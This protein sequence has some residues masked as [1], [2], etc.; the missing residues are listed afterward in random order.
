M[1]SRREVLAT[2]A[3]AVGATALPLSAGAP[4]ARAAVADPDP[5]R[6]PGRGPNV[7]LIVLDD[8][9]Y[10]DLGCYGSELI[11]TPHLDRLARQGTRFTQGY[12][13]A[14]V[15][16]PSRAALLTGRVPPR[17]GVR[18][19]LSRD[20]SQGLRAAEKTLPGYLRD[21][22][23]HTA[24]IG[25]WHLGRLDENHPSRHGFDSYFGVDAMFSED[26]YPTEIWR[27][28]A[29]VGT[30]RDDADLATLTRRFT[31]EAIDVIDRAGKRPFFIYL[32]E[33]MPHLPLA[34][35]P[36]F[37][38]IS[39]GGLYGDAVESVDHHLGR[40]FRAL[41]DRGLERDTLVIVASDNGPWFEGSTGGLRGRKSGCYEGGVRV[42][43]LMR[44]TGTVPRGRE[45]HQVVSFLD[46]LPTLCGLAG[47]VP[48]PGVKLDGTDLRPVLRGERLRERPPVPFFLGRHAAAVRDGRWKLHV[49][50]AG[51]N[52]R[53]L[54]ELFDLEADP[55]E[56][57]NVAARRPEVTERLRK[58]LAALEEDVA[59]ERRPA[60]ALTAKPPLFAGRAN[61]LRVRLSR[62]LRP[63]GGG[64]KAKVS[65]T[66]AVPEGWTA[67]T[68]RK[69]VDLTAAPVVEIDVTPPP[70]AG[71]PAGRLR[72]HRLTPLVVVDGRTVTG[73][74]VQVHA[75][76]HGRD[77][78]LALDA[79]PE[80]RPALPSYRHLTPATAWDRAAGF[81]WVSAP[82]QSRAH[83][84]PDPLRRGVVRDRSAAVLR[85][86]LAAGRRRI[87]LLRGDDKRP[88]HGFTVAA[89][90]ETVIAPGPRLPAGAY[91]W[92]EFVLDGGPEGRTIE[93]GLSGTGG[94][95]WTLVALVVH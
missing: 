95:R 6:P 44:W 10:G 73:A 90:G 41:A 14:P 16:S 54:P 72:G 71:A 91:R 58:Y 61:T 74:D 82:P 81:G 18:K 70:S 4:N 38:G 50:R 2:S 26:S 17:T 32:A 84:G 40:L 69:A 83:A 13:G 65:V 94:N 77:A 56:V 8:L 20:D 12:S 68:V 53:F 23:Y 48:D 47:A 29:P 36:E 25:K 92:E 87:S 88:T 33:T 28:G 39:R 11:D 79:G 49:R 67:T 66:V 45:S 78:A 37:D 31:D 30:L 7:V 34:V 52:Q 35:E 3:V 27:D 62:A 1:A 5:T 63:E 64:G 9:G 51:R 93:L 15:C 19:V 85:L 59:A 76:P 55:R 22:G 80:G 75:V 24:A 86:R 60:V 42:P 89:D 21:A 46:V 43:F 57:A